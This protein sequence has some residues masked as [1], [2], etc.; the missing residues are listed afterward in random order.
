MKNLYGVGQETPVTNHLSK[1]SIGLD[2]K[3][4]Q[5]LL[6]A[7]AVARRS[8]HWPVGAIRQET[9]RHFRI[10]DHEIVDLRFVTTESQCSTGNELFRVYC[11]SDAAWV[12]YE[13]KLIEH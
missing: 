8:L 11:K 10:T 5:N 12:G 1:L 7:L 9:G 6:L 3:R 2:I 13:I 4:T